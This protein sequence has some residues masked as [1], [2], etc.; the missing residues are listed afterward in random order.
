MDRVA[1]YIASPYT[2][3]DVGA[4]VA[5]SFRVADILLELG[6]LPYPP[7]WTHFWHILSP[8]SYDEWMEMDKE[9][10]L[11]CD[12]IFRVIGESR[13]ADQEVKFAYENGMPVF[14]A[15]EDLCKWRYDE[16]HKTHP[17]G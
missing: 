8:K 2:L 7:L 9:W 5:V 14:F 15:F 6:F 12:V 11:R 16:R 17:C 13:G 4:N 10:I 3:G 1:V